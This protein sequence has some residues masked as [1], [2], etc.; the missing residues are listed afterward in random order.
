MFIVIPTGISFSKSEFIG[1]L[2]LVSLCATV[3]SSKSRPIATL[4]LLE[5]LLWAG[6]PGSVGC[7]GLT[8]G[9]G[10]S[11]TPGGDCGGTTVL[12]RSCGWVPIVLVDCDVRG[13]WRLGVLCVPLVGSVGHKWIPG[14][15]PLVPCSTLGEGGWCLNHLLS[16]QC[17]LFL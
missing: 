10:P 9:A 5:E 16:K 13:W 8:E 1:Q 4:L 2:I 15:T 12:G 3:D 11:R 17:N 7:F 6:L 14:T